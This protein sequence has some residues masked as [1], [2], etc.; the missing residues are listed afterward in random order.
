[1][2]FFSKLKDKANAV[3]KTAEKYVTNEESKKV[4]IDQMPQEYQV[5]Q[6]KPK[7]QAVPN[8]MA[9][10]EQI[11]SKPR[12]VKQQPVTMMDPLSQM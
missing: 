2:S 10:G 9:G 4:P 12:Q 3:R 6:T 11:E 1:M 8:S 7:G 5:K